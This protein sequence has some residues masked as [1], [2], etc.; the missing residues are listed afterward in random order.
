[1]SEAELSELRERVAALRPRRLAVPE[2]RHAAVLLPLLK[3]PSEL[4]VLF[5]VRSGSLSTHA[6]QIAFPGGGL[7]P[8]E[9]V[10]EAALREAREEIGLA[11]GNDQLWGRLDDQV[12]PAKFVVTPLVA[13]LPWPQ[14]LTINPAEV[15]EV[16][17]APLGELAALT[18]RSEERRLYGIT[19]RIY[20]YEWRERL[21]WGMTANILKDFLDLAAK[22]KRGN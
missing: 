7:E 5:T 21:I 2:V 17:A 9:S 3:A 10:E 14:A 15:E 1:M 20:F 13:A 16:F 6:G 18:P 8:G 12:S 4:G 19:R 22:P 11:V